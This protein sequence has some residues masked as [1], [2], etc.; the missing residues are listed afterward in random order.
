M[1]R[2]REGEQNTLT[3]DRVKDAAGNEQ[4]CFL[5][6][7]N[8]IKCVQTTERDTRF[9]WLYQFN[10]LLWRSFTEEKIELLYFCIDK[11]TTPLGRLSF[12][13]RAEGLNLHKRGQLLKQNSNAFS[14]ILN[15]ESALELLFPVHSFFHM[16]FEI[17]LLL[18]S[19]LCFQHLN[20]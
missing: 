6:L 5:S 16:F 2:N 3:D 15:A 7:V 4:R 10:N 12:N 13:G 8:P 9:L 11:C 17:K 1:Q 14:N 18:N 20:I 19:L